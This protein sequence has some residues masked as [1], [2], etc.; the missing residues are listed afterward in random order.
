MQKMN[1]KNKAFLEKV[2]V[3]ESNNL[4]SL[5][6]ILATQFSIM[7]GWGGTLLISQKVNKSPP[8]RVSHHQIFTSLP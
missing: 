8:I 7:C 6:N 1:L 5:E 2:Y 3:K 4:I